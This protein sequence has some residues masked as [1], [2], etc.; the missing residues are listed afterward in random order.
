VATGKA[1]ETPSCSSLHTTSKMLYPGPWVLAWTPL[2]APDRPQ[3]R[4]VACF[5]GVSTRNHDMGVAGEL[6]TRQG[7]QNRLDQCVCKPVQG[8]SG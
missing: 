3:A 7:W 1:V 6:Q 2:H 8:W 5:K 4:L